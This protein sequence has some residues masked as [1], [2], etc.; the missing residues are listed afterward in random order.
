M[1]Q[2]E[3]E[4]LAEF[5]ERSAPFEEL[6]HTFEK[7]EQDYDRQ[8]KELIGKRCTVLFLPFSSLTEH[9][10]LALLLILFLEV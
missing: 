8:K 3:S 6:C 10:S 1:T 2:E 4:K 9:E 7:A 5:Q